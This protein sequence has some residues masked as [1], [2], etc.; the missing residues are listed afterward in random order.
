MYCS[1][2]LKSW[3]EEKK[4]FQKTFIIRGWPHVYFLSLF[5]LIQTP[6]YNVFCN[7]PQQKLTVVYLMGL[8]R[9]PNALITALCQ[10]SYFSGPVPEAVWEEISS[11]NAVVRLLGKVV[12][13]FGSV[14]FHFKIW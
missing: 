4:N 10:V 6:L 7:P 5:N 1:A 8:T 12:V 14:Q 11:D 13:Y 3:D 2:V 9:L